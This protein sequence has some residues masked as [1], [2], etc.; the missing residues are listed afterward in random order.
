MRILVEA[1]N[2]R[3]IKGEEKEDFVYVFQNVFRPVTVEEE[4]AK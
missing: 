4:I 2:E 3:D 1:M